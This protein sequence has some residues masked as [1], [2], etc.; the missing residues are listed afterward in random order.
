MASKHDNI[1]IHCSAGL[2]RS[3]VIAV[4]L[5][6]VE[7]LKTMSNVSVF[8]EVRKMREDRYG[9]VQNSHQYKFIY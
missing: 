8:R 6:M 3:G 5:N 4:I 1:L 2:G 9:A 7:K